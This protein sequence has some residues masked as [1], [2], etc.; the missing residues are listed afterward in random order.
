MDRPLLEELIDALRV[1]PGVGPKSA[2]RMAYHLLQHHRDGGMQ[3]GEVLKQAMT[4]IG[5]CSRC[6]MYTENNL[7]S[8]CGNEQRTAQQICVVET[9]ADRSSIES[10]TGYHGQ[11]FLLLGRLS[12]LDGIGPEQLGLN[13][14]EKRLEDEPIEEMIIATNPTVEGEAT[15]HYLSHLASRHGVRASRIAHGVPVGGEL[16]FTDRNTLA[17]AFSGRLDIED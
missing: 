8:L 13:L 16:E 4:A 9:P 15:A 5:H 2:Q 11:Y 12:P 1:L 17:H 10:A 3:L 14:L 6:R 7:C